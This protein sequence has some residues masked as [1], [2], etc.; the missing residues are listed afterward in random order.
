MVTTGPTGSTPAACVLLAAALLCGFPRPGPA[1]LGRLRPGRR[2]RTRRALTAG[3]LLAGALTGLVV[4]GPGGALA[5]LL[6]AAVVRRRRTRRAAART[7]D[8]AATQLADALRRLTDELR[9]GAHPALALAADCAD[10]P[11]ASALLAP[12]AA[13][14]GLGGDVATAWRRGGERHPA[15]ATDLDRVAA[16]WSLAERHGAP[17]ADLL[18]DAHDTIRWRL[19]FAAAVRAQLAGPRATATVLTGLPGL[20]LAFGQLMG[21]DP[22]G[23]LRGGWLGQTLLMTGVGLVAVGSAWSERLLATAVPR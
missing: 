3:P 15:L 6:V 7:D 4:V 22:L 12:V 18:A 19:R 1:R 16:A 10:A 21:A 20:G 5:G 17:L 14:A 9:A 13:A 2:R 11:L 8:A 23:V